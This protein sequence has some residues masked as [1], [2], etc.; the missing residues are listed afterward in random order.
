MPRKKCTPEQIIQKLREAEI[1]LG[2]GEVIEQ[3]CRNLAIPE[4]SAYRWRKEYGG[5]AITIPAAQ[6]P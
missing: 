4:Q 6:R 5:A 2:Q 3:V 1:R